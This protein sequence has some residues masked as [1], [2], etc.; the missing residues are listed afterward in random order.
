MLNQIANI[1]Q[2]PESCLVNKKITKAFFK[3][4]FELTLSERILLDDFSMVVSIDW[5][6]SIS[7]LNANVPSIFEQDA[8]YEELQIIVLQTNSEHLEKQSKKLI[9]FVQKYIPYHIILIVHDGSNFIW[10]ACT[11]RINSTDN[12]KRIIDKSFTSELI[13]HKQPNQKHIAFLE[14]LN[15]TVLDKTS[16]KT[17]YGSSIQQI[18]A[19][20]TA[21]I[22]GGY[23]PR[24][25]K[26]TQQDVAY[27]EQITQIEKEIVTLNNL[28]KKESQMNKRVELNTQLQHKRKQIENIKQ[29]I[30][31]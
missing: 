1:L 3:R 17:V 26:R 31:Q 20:Q 12:N 14:N 13:N 11:K 29:L 25:A 19:L 22:K 6:A 4:N 16:L 15:F 10:N 23:M 7:P 18:V 28:A 5:L 24:T 9:E 30:T 2:L 8:T 27:L 21:D